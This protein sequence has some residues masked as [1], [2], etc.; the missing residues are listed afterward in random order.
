MSVTS[1]KSN[2]ESN[3]SNMLDLL[4]D[5]FYSDYKVNNYNMKMTSKYNKKY[6]DNIFNKTKYNIKKNNFY[7]FPNN[8][9]ITINKS[10]NNSQINKDNSMFKENNQHHISSQHYVSS[11]QNSSSLFNNL[12]LR[13]KQKKFNLNTVYTNNYH[14][15]LNNDSKNSKK[16]NIIDNNSKM[17]KSFLSQN[18]SN[19]NNKYNMIYCVSNIKQKDH[20]TKLFDSI[21]KRQFKD[22]FS[23]YLNKRCYSAKKMNFTISKN[24]TCDNGWNK[25][26]FLNQSNDFMENIAHRNH[27]IKIKT[28]D[29]INDRSISSDK[30]VNNEPIFYKNNALFKTLPLK[31]KKKNVFIK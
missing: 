11:Q 28:I 2:K 3:S 31:K 9:C 5:T 29:F 1:E 17:F 4:K 21:K 13:E 23:N 26:I 20:I 7:W 24:L 25:K 22:N 6:K 30:I 18:K 10:I 15:Y 27:L 8:K 19:F 16:Y 14:I 12:F